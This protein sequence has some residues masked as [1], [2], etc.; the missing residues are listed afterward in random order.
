MDA[1]LGYLLDALAAI[2][3]LHS[4]AGCAHGL[5]APDRTVFTPDGGLVFLDPAYAAVVERLGL[6]RRRLWTE[7]GIAAPP[8]TGPARLDQTV[9]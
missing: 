5:I 9:T 3:A 6:S 7:F 8:G 4:S 2:A 1:A